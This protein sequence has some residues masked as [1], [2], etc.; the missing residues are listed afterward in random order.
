M[1]GDDGKAAGFFCAVN[2]RTREVLANRELRASEARHRGVLSRMDEGFLLLD[3]EFRIAEVNDYTL[4]LNEL[5]REQMLGHLHWDVFRGSENLEVGRLYMQAMAD[6]KPFT[7][8]H[9]YVWRDGRRAWIE[10]RGYPTADGLAI[11]FRDV[12]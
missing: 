10:L 1:H 11:F 6:R 7:F 5:R 9:L 4:R 2:E 12:T 8:E 3:R